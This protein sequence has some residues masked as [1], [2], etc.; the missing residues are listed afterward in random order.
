MIYSLFLKHPMEK[1]YTY[2]EHLQRAWTLGWNLL[3]GSAALFVH[4]V[5]PA[6]F[7]DTGS[8]IIHDAYKKVATSMMNYESLHHEC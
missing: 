8:T 6:Y 7:E 4:G 2:M 3:K 1:G 5:V